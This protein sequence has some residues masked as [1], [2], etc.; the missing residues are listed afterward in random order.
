LAHTAGADSVT[1]LRLEHDPQAGPGSL[2]EALKSAGR[3]PHLP[4][5]DARDD[6]SRRDPPSFNCSS[7]ERAQKLRRRERDG[8]ADEQAG[9]RNA[10]QR[11]HDATI[12]ILPAAQVSTRERVSDDRAG[13]VIRQQ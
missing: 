7:W 3:R 12:K 13:I 4:S 6:S 1:G 10:G 11:H 5:F 2:G 8:P 9:N